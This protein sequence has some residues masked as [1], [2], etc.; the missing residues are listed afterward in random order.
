[1]ILRLILEMITLRLTAGAGVGLAAETT[2]GRAAAGGGGG[3]VGAA[4]APH[5]SSG[6]EAL[7]RVELEWNPAGAAEGAK[8]GA[9]GTGRAAAGGGGGCVWCEGAAALRLNASKSGLPMGT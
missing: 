5:A 7:L 9:A 4:G 3:F 2:G 6:A 8:R 1:M